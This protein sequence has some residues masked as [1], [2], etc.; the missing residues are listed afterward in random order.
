MQE[1]R[2]SCIFFKFLVNFFRKEENR[3]I[4]KTKKEDENELKIVE[5]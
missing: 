5:A 2:F 1:C 3:V 4:K